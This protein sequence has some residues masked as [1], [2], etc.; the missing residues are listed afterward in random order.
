MFIK[1]IIILLITIFIFSCGQS[2][3]ELEDTFEPK[4]VVE[5]FIYPN[6][7]V[8]DI[9]ITKNFPLNTAPNA[10]E[11]IIRDAKV[12]ITDL[13]TNKEYNLVFN[14]KTFCYEY[15]SNDLIIEYD[16]EYQLKVNATIYGK[17][18]TAISKTKTPQKGFAIVKEKTVSGT[19]SYRQKDENGFVKNLPLVFK[20]SEGTSFYPVS[21]VALDASE[22]NFIYDNAYREVKKEDVIKD[23]DNFKFRQRQIFNVNSSGSFY[24]YEIT[25]TAIWFYGRYRMVVYAADENYRQFS[26]TYRNVQEFDG[27]FHEPKITIQGDGIGVFASMIADTVYFSIKK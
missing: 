14:S 21:I 26:L 11:L 8:N 4:I 23:L 15:N 17:N 13:K 12:T 18:L 5:A 20:I 25:W 10:Q 9:S 2:V 1:R 19:L 24:E 6:Q 27:N 7:K 16:R 3:V 22:P